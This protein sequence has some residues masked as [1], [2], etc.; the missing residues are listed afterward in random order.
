M[1]AHRLTSHI[2]LLC[3]AS[4][5]LAR[6]NHTHW[7]E[8]ASLCI[9]ILCDDVNAFPKHWWVVRG[10]EGRAHSEGRANSGGHENENGGCLGSVPYGVYR[11]RDDV[12][13]S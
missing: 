3:P 11:H 8:L 12:S 1:R 6:I 4:V 9:I 2:I 5:R 13:V 7:E 10:D